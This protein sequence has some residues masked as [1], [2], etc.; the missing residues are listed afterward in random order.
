MSESVSATQPPTEPGTELPTHR[1][2]TDEEFF[3]PANR[4]R[5]YGANFCAD[6]VVTCLE[7]DGIQKDFRYVHSMS[8]FTVGYASFVKVQDNT[9][10]YGKPKI[11]E[12]VKWMKAD[13]AEPVLPTE[14]SRDIKTCR[15]PEG[16]ILGV[17]ILTNMV[18]IPDP[19]SSLFSPGTSANKAYNCAIVVTNPSLDG[20]AETYGWEPSQPLAQYRRCLDHG[21]FHPDPNEMVDVPARGGFDTT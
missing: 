21:A 16:N 7:V 1:S 5:S 6:G 18:E 14:D 8:K 15:D 12:E 3:R 11:W 10:E 19:P 17:M 13:E 4:T 2:T 20:M 9:L